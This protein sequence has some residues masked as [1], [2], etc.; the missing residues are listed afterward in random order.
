M[1]KI[2]FLMFLTFGSIFSQDPNWSSFITF[3]QYPSPYFTDWER[4]PNIGSLNIN[5]TGTAPVE[6]YFEV[7]IS[8]DEYGEA[9]KGRTENKEYLS[10]PVSEMLTFNDISDWVSTKINADLER[11]IIQTGKLPESD[12]SICVSAYKV[13]GDLLTDACTNFEIALPNCFLS[14]A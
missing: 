8:L 5:Y 2:M 11:V 4:N 10:G 3:P 7:V 9:I 1:R 6:F 12:Y 14:F 13:N